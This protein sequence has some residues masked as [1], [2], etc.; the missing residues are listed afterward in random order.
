MQSINRQVS[1]SDVI[2]GL[3]FSN[4]MLVNV[5]QNVLLISEQLF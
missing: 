4:F 2:C 1:K 5:Y 3:K